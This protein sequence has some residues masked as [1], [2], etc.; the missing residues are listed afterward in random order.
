MVANALIEIIGSYDRVLVMGHQ[1]GDLDSIGSAVGI[2]DAIKAMG[3]ESYV[4]TDR[5][6]NLA[7]TLI[8]HIEENSIKKYFITPKDAMTKLDDSTLLI[9]TDTHN[10]AIVDC[11]EL[12]EHCMH[13][14]VIDH[15]RLIINPIDDT[16][17]FYHEPSASS[18]C[19]MVAELLEYF[20]DT[21]LATPIAEGLLS[22]IMLDT[23]NFIM[24]TGVRTFEAA[25][26]LKRQ[27]ADTV[28]VKR[29]FS[30]SLDTYR[31]KAAIIDSTEIYRKC[32]I[33]VAEQSCDNIRIASSKA[34]DEMLEITGVNA[35]FVIYRQGE[36]VNISARSLGSYNVQLIME[37]LGGGGHHTMAACQ[38]KCTLKDA[39]RQLGNAIDEYIRNN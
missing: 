3:R 4:V 1:C 20:P 6:K 39:R 8:E 27:G 35:S 10:P 29:L 34:A 32:A 21:S 12:L 30:N 17:L 26:F 31:G 38:L 2:C 14:V 18:A 11:K 16:E 9:I 19:E 24:N 37:T 25:A 22:G 13:R 28:S 33:A 5:S 23:K 7:T 15:H 36:T